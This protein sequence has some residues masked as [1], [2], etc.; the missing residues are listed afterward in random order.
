[1]AIDSKNNFN[2]YILNGSSDFARCQL[3]EH[4]SDYFNMN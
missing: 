4:C 3:Q 2:P 1:M